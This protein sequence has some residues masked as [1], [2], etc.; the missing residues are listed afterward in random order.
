MTDVQDPVLSLKTEQDFQKF[1]KDTGLSLTGQRYVLVPLTQPKRVDPLLD[2]IAVPNPRD[3]VIKS[4][5]FGVPQSRHRVMICGIR[6]DIWNRNGS[7]GFLNPNLKLTVLRDLLEGM[8]DLISRLTNED[9]D[10]EKWAGFVR[11]EISRLTGDR[12]PKLTS[13]RSYGLSFKNLKKDRPSPCEK[14][15]FD[16]KQVLDHTTRA[17]MKSDLAR[18]YYC[19][20]FAK[21]NSKNPKIEDWPVGDI[22]PKHA[23]IK[24]VGNRA[25]AD[26]FSDRFKVQL[27]DKPS[28]TITSHI[29]K[30]G[31]YYIHP[32]S[33]QCRS[34]SVREAARLQTF[35]DSYR[36]EGGLSRQFHQIGNAVPPFLA[37][38]IGKIIKNYLGKLDG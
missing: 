29:S 26:G 4:E 33:S 25:R 14:F 13:S 1:C 17:H 22:L 11:S 21:E 37:F 38:Q 27:W 7:P 3:F 5:D 18:Y 34:L 8:P 19:S 2:G 23:G 35:P 36:F 10:P 28:S 20:Q 31:H 30:D 12:A 15:V 24:V 32:D 6:Q 9:A 16:V